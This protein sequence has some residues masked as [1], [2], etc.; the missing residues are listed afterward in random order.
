VNHAGL[1][2]QIQYIPL[3]EDHEWTG[4]LGLFTDITEQRNALIRLKSATQELK[5]L[6]D[7]IPLGIFYVE[8][9]KIVRVNQLSAVLLGYTQAELLKMTVDHLYS[10]MREYTVFQQ[11]ALPFISK[12]Q[13]YSV[14]HTLYCK[15]GTPVRCKI[16]VEPLNQ[17]SR[18]LWFIEEIQD[19]IQPEQDLTEALL[20]T[21]EEAVL[22]TNAQLL[23]EKINPQVNQLTGYTTE[24]L[25]GQ[26]LQKLDAGQTDTTQIYQ[27]I[28]D[29]LT[30]QHQWQG[31]I[32]QR[33]KK[34]T[35]YLCHLK[36]K[37]Y[38]T[39][40]GTASHYVVVLKNPLYQQ[41][42][43]IDALTQ[44]PNGELFRFSL[45]KTLSL[46]QRAR[47]RFAVLLVSI[48]AI[49]AV[50]HQHGYATG[51]LLLYQTG[52]NLKATVRDSDT[53]ARYEGNIFG[54]SLDEIAQPPDAG[55]VGQ[56]ILFK[57]TQPITLNEQKIQN[58]IS[59]G[60]A[61]YPEDGD[62][63]ETLLI[64]AQKALQRAQQLGGGQCCF[65]DPKLQEL[66]SPIS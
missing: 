28:L 57:L 48:D 9:R 45:L 25:T 64:L 41:V 55:L 10:S 50:N 14:E 42:P 30:Q 29:S 52:Q 39:D 12:S 11:K 21:T 51:D 4:T 27:Q 34:G 61:I 19:E 53:V 54:A 24:E 33:H 58:S 17:P 7:R 37:A 60:I 56:M 16:T 20:T 23:I 49:V 15:T 22:I 31:Q 32:W 63:V 3:L 18:T 62:T 26:S 66:Y 13:S 40:A 43:G 44:L 65:Y 47:R 59:I 46:A 2:L 5:L 8:V 1:S 36:L 6:T 38:N 35:A